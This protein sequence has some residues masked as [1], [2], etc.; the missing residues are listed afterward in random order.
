MHKKLENKVP[1]KTKLKNKDLKEIEPSNDVNDGTD[2][3]AN[4][5][6]DEHA[7]ETIG[8]NDEDKI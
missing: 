1:I 2:V 7:H 6:Y 8:L 5:D 3:L 4:P